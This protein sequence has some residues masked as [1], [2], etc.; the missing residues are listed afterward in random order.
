MEESGLEMWHLLSCPAYR[1]PMKLSYSI[2]PDE[3]CQFS[4][5]V[6]MD[7]LNKSE[8]SLIVGVITR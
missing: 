7:I 3:K 2:E 6:N 1:V 5:Y 4:L 8:G